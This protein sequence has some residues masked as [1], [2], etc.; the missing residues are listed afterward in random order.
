MMSSVLLSS[1]GGGLLLRGEAVSSL[2]GV[3]VSPQGRSSLFLA[4][5]VPHFSLWDCCCLVQRA[6]TRLPSGSLSPLEAEDL[7]RCDI[8][9]DTTLVMPGAFA[10]VL[11]REPV[12][13]LAQWPLFLLQ[14]TD[15]VKLQQGTQGVSWDAAC[16]S[17]LF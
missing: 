16:D 15:P 4:Q 5:W 10:S 12:H 11:A 3:C 2:V 17:D 13:H 9:G 8:L 6:S 14:T 7:S 1:C